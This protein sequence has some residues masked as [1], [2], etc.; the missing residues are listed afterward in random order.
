MPS[1]PKTSDAEIVTAT[2]RLLERHGRDGFSLADIAEAVGIRAPSLYKRFAYR[3]ALVSAVELELWRELS[4]AL[5]GASTSADPVQRLTAQAHAYRAFAKAHPRL[6][7]L[8]YDASAEHTEAGQRARAEA[9]AASLPAFVAL[10]GERDALVA[11][12]VL[13]PYIHGFV[14]MELAGAFRLGSGLDAAFS[15]GVATVL[16]GLRAQARSRKSRA[17]SKE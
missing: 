17:H 4:A 16:S 3:A 5:A 6:Y 9:V 12:R 2:R 7:A 10:V 15:Y 1:P 8:I 13:T 14:A 11:A